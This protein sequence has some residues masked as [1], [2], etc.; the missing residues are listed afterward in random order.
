MA[1]IEEKAIFRLAS[2]RD[3]ALRP[4]RKG[5]HLDHDLSVHSPPL[6]G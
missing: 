6:F 4:L 5:G 2:E 3:R 1:A